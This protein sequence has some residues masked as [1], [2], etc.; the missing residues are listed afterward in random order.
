MR[1]LKRA[2]SLV[3]AM[4]LIVGMM[5]VSA[6]AAG[7]DFTD[8]D[9]IDHKEAVNT[10]V[11][12]N[13]IDG[14]EDGSYYDPAGTLTRAE[15]AK[16]IAF[17]M[18]GGVEPNIGTKVIPTYSD[19]DGHWAEAYIEYCTSM[20]IIAGDGAG[21][22]NPGGTLTAEQAAKM[23]LTAMGYDANVFGFVGNDW[24]MN[25]G[26]YANEAG[27]YKQ[28][29][30]VRSSQPISRDDAAQM[31]YNAIQATMMRRTWSQDMATGQL[32]ETYQPWID[33]WTSG[34]MA[35]SRAHTLFTEKFNGITYEGVLTASGKYSINNTGAKESL[36]MATVQKVNGVTSSESFP[37][38]V[39]YEDVTGLVG[40]YVKVLMNQDTDEVYGVYAVADKN[41][42]DVVTTQDQ[43]KFDSAAD[44]LTVEG[45][46]YDADST[47]VVYR[48]G[49][50][51]GV[52]TETI[53]PKTTSKAV[54]D[55]VRVYDND[56]D[57]EIDLILI[58]TIA[59][60]K[61]NYVGTDSF[62]ISNQSGTRQSSADGKTSSAS[63]YTSANQK[64]ADVNAPETLAKGD[65]VLITED[66]YSETD[67]YE[68]IIPKSATINGTKGS[69][70]VTEWML[71]DT[72]YRPFNA[73]STDNLE[74]A[75]K[76]GETVDYIAYGN[77]TYYAVKTSDIA[78]IENI[79]LVVTAGL[80]DENGNISAGTYQAVLMMSDGT[81]TPVQVVNEDGTQDSDVADLVGKLVTFRTTSGG[82]YVLSAIKTGAVGTDYDDYIPS[83]KPAVSGSSTTISK[84]GTTDIADDAVVFVMR[85]K[86]A[87]NTGASAAH[88]GNDATVLTGKEVKTLAQSTYDVNVEALVSSVNGFDYVKVMTLFNATPDQKLP[89]NFDGTEYGYLVADSYENYDAA[90]TTWYRNYRIWNGTE[91]ITVKEEGIGELA[92]ADAGAVISYRMGGEGLVESVKV[93]TPVLTQVTGYDE[94]NDK[95]AVAAGL[96]ATK[97]TDDTVIFYVNSTTHEGFSEGTIAIADDTHDNGTPGQ[98][99]SDD[100][101]NVRVIASTAE[102]H[103]DEWAFI[104]VDVNNKM[105]AGPV[106]SYSAGDGA[107]DTVAEINQLLTDGN[108]V[109]ITGNVTLGGAAISVPADRTLTITGNL[110][111]T[112]QAMTVD[113]TLNVT[114]TLTATSVTLNDADASLNV[115]GAVSANVTVTAANTVEVGNITGTLDVDSANTVKAGNVSGAISVKDA[116]V[117]VDAASDNITVEAASSGKTSSL[118]VASLNWSKTISNAGTLTVRNAISAHTSA[119][120][121][122]GGTWVFSGMF[123]TDATNATT[124]A[125]STTVYFNGGITFSAADKLI[126]ADDTSATMIVAE[127]TTATTNASESKIVDTDGTAITS[128]SIAGKTFKGAGSDNKFQEQA[129]E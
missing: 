63:T 98:I 73:D 38:G 30:D 52:V 80:G 77:V 118:S 72:W 19:I 32:T 33:S 7:N 16:I 10:M 94:D 84:V 2:L 85:Y 29:G 126:A 50:N 99:T 54:G 97:I 4:A 23:F 90:N 22:F 114:G 47:C 27:L 65:F 82:K 45:V 26:R 49:V 119:Y 105:A 1:N 109:A 81:K 89:D 37:A 112:S 57:N 95:M 51:Q 128:A 35:Y 83:A 60:G 78:S 20:G 56:G 71:D 110:A 5:V 68:V 3:M 42:V 93:L 9:E 76:G 40:Q 59:V 24:A 91:I 28:L 8:M 125:A 96:G 43:V 79:A 88:G 13:V 15:M 111:N 21:K 129:A 67:T 36:K 39:K 123:T 108:D 102:G 124:I 70:P 61:V 53:F 104:L 14:K 106:R 101:A 25:V 44:E 103:T 69:S 115:D 18:N 116:A 34:G 122:T 113:G 17:V 41:T 62:S 87:S 31:A 58:E 120:T 121:I 64:Y 48:D 11:A 55:T 92:N 46:T 6:S 117:T 86:N 74:D 127:N 12:L 107:V 66:Y 100:Q 75:M